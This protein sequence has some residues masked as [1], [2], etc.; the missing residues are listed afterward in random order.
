MR[1]S[2]YFGEDAN[3]YKAHVEASRPLILANLRR[4][5]EFIGDGAKQ[6][7]PL[8]AGIAFRELATR[9]DVPEEVVSE[10]AIVHGLWAGSMEAIRETAFRE[11]DT[12][13]GIPEV[14]DTQGRVRTVTCRLCGATVSRLYEKSRETDICGKSCAARQSGITQQKPLTSSRNK[15]LPRRAVSP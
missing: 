1:K 10:I 13:R 12:A 4:L 15:R 8:A 11:S 6:F 14:P 9:M 3:I 2:L 5:L 7:H